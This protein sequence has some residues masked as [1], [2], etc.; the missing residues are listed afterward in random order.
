MRN[1]SLTTSFPGYNNKIDSSK[2]NPGV[3]VSGSH[4]VYSVDGLRVASRPGYTLV[5]ETNSALTPIVAS[6]DWITSGSSERN[7]RAY[8][9]KLELLYRGNWIQLS[10]G[11]SSVNF[12]FTEWW[13]TT[14][15]ED[16][17][18]FCNGTPDLYVWNGAVAEILSVTANTL[19]KTGTETWAE[20][21]FYIDAGSTKQVNINGV[22]YTYTGGETTTTLTGVTPSPVTNGVVATD[23]CTQEVISYANLISSSYNLGILSVLDNQL[24]IADTSKRDVYVSKLNDFTDFTFASPR[25]IGEGALLTLDACPVG[26]AVQEEFMWISAGRDLWYQSALTLSDDNTKESLTV[27]RLKTAPQQGALSQSAIGKLKNDTVFISNEPTLD[28]LGNVENISGKQSTVISDPIKN[29]FDN[30]TFSNNVNLKYYKN[31]LYV[32]IPEESKLL[33]YNLDGNYWEAPWNLPA[34][35]LAII[36]G[37][38]HIHSNAVPETYKLFDGYSDN[39]NPIFARALFA[40][41]S[42]GVKTQTKNFEEWYSEGFASTNTNLKNKINYEYNGVGGSV[43]KDI[44]EAT[45]PSPLIATTTSALGKTNLGKQKL[46]GTSDGDITATVNKFRIINTFSPL[47][48]Y[49]IQ[50]EYWSNDVDQRWE[51]LVFGGDIRITNYD[52]NIIKN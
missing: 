30:Y 18:L 21:R 40:L 26:F 15:I 52:N 11:F 14:E 3:L 41:D 50:P 42:S 45:I 28:F 38:L 51:L 1:F 35:R 31:N 6:Y 8:D 27:K 33:I 4:D 20:S 5:G 2:L 7:L 49:E 9:D 24:W 22:T 10:D 25:A 37:E 29:D 34:G 47:D 43:T 17:I 13:N 36:E 19:T 44:S 12:N 32:A 39:G 48:Y 46:G 16:E 23:I